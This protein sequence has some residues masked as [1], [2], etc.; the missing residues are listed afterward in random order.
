[1]PIVTRLFVRTG[2]L[3]LVAA[4]L[5]GVIVV[6]NSLLRLPAWTS[7]LTPAYFHLFMVGWVTQLIIGVAYWMFPKLSRSRP[8]G[9]DLLAWGCYSLLNLGLLLRVVAEPLNTVQPDPVLGWLVVAAALLQWLG[10]VAFVINT[11]QRVKER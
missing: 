3:Y 5:T 7:A 8:R 9:S 11:W 2:L 10:G 4:L 6:G 1:L